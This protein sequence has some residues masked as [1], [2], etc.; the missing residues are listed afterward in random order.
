[1]TKKD[2]RKQIKNSLKEN[3]SSLPELSR[4]ICSKI[5][6]S[7]LYTS[8]DTIL[9]YMALPDEVDLQPVLQDALNTGKQ[10]YLPKVDPNSPQMEFYLYSKSSSTEQGAFGIQEPDI[11][12][13]FNLENNPKTLVLVPGRGFTDKGDRLGRGKAY[14]DTYFGSLA[15]K[16]TLAGVCFS[17]QMLKELPSEPH[18]V[19][20]DYII[21]E[22]GIINTGK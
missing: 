17:L 8:S 13:P 12:V 15:G 1:M 10:I 16:I 3:S 19:L 21:N 4:Q 18:D 6:G 9:A 5:I 11:T 20:M 7:P 14:Y 2:I 22:K